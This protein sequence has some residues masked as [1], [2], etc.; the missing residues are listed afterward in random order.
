[1][2]KKSK[3]ERGNGPLLAPMVWLAL[4]AIGR[5][6]TAR[7]EGILTPSIPGLCSGA[8]EPQTASH[9][10]S[11][12]VPLSHCPVSNR[13]VIIGNGGCGPHVYV[14]SFT[15]SNGF[16]RI[17][18]N[19]GGQLAFLYHPGVQLNVS[20]IVINNGGKFEAG[21]SLCPIGSANPSDVSVIRF[22]PANPPLARGIEGIT[23]NQGG[24]LQLYGKTGVAPA[25]PLSVAD[26]QA[27]SWTYLSAPAGPPDLYSAGMGVGNPVGSNGAT[28]LQLADPVD[29]QPGQW[30]V[31]AGTDFSPDSAEFVQISAVSN[32]T[33]QS[34]S[35]IIL[36]STTPLV[37]YHFG[38]PAPDLGANAFNDGPSQNYGVDERAEV[39]LISR[40]LKLTSSVASEP[41]WAPNKQYTARAS[42]IQV[43]TTTFKPLV[44]FAATIAGTSGANPPAWP[45]KVGATVCDGGTGKTCKGGV[46]WKNM[47]AQTEM[48][49]EIR[50][51]AGYKKVEIQGV[52]LEKFG[53]DQL[54]SYPI[55]FHMVGDAPVK[56]TLINSNSIHHGYNHCIAL[57]DTN[58]V[59][60]SNNVCARI[61]DHLYY[62]ETGAETGN[63]FA[64][65]LGI[66]AMSNNFSIT[67]NPPALA[68][69]WPGD[70]LA[71]VNGYNGFN[72]PFTDG[73][74]TAPVIGANGNTSSGFWVTNPG[75]NK[76]VGNSI[77]GCQATG[78]GFWILPASSAIAQ[79]PLPAGHFA[80]NRA[81]GC[82]TGFDTAADD[83]VSGAFLYI[84]Q[85]KCLAGKVKGAGQCDAIA[86]FDNLTATRNRNRGIWV[87]A[88]WYHI[89]GARLAT[90]RDGVSLVSSGGSEG[91]P[92]G[93]W[94]LL[95]DSIAV[96]ISTNNPNRFGP[97]PYVGQNGFGGN[98]GCYEPIQDNG[99]PGPQWN[100]FG[101]M[102][103]DG[104][105]RIENVK[106]VNFKVDPISMLTASDVSF[107]NYFSA[108]NT[109]PCGAPG[110]FKY[111]GDASMGWF[112]SN[113]NSYPP[114]QYTE[115]VSYENVDLRHEIYTGSVENTCSSSSGGANFRDGD[116][117]TVIRDH[118][119]SLTGLEV[120]PQGG[121][122]PVPG[123]LP[124]SL[125]NLPFL[126]G[127]GTV[128]E[129]LS[130]GAQDDALE[131]RPTSLISP[132]NY[133]TLEFAAIT[134]PCNGVQGGAP[135]VNDNVMVF[136]KDEIDYPDLDGPGLIQ[137]T[138]RTITANDTNYS[139]NCGAGA[140]PSSPGVPGHACVALSGRN[141][142]GTYE[143]KVVNGL[144]YTVQAQHGMPNF[145]TLMYGDADVPGGISSANPFRTRIGICYKNEG[146]SAPPV[147][148]F[149]VYKGS[150]SFA[151]PDL[152]IAPLAGYYTPLS[153]NGLDDIMCGSTP[154]CFETKCPSAPYYSTAGDDAVKTKL[155]LATSIAQLD[156]SSMCPNG[157]CYYYDQHSGLLFINMAQE[158]PNA[159]GPYS[160]PLGSCGGS[161]SKANDSACAPENFYSCPGPGCELYT[162][163]VKGKDYSPGTPSDCTPYSGGDTTDYTQ[164]YPSNLNQLA[165]ASND[166]VVQ[167]ALV[168]ADTHYP[169]QEASNPPVDICPINAPNTPDWPPASPSAIPTDYTIS[170]PSG[171]SIALA[172]S[173]GD[174]API[175]Q[176]VGNEL[177]ALSPGLYTLTASL[178]GC[179]TNSKDSSCTCEQDFTVTSSGWSSA[180]N[181]NC[182]QLGTGGSMTTIGVADGPYA[183]AGPGP[184]P[185]PTP[186]P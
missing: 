127:P 148:A 3:I 154:F 125:N 53:K 139:I 92:P 147:D 63:T 61:V 126:A 80:S 169:H 48:G 164:D 37:N 163:K 144:G 55:H 99:Y 41:Q 23:V 132:Y 69:F 175:L 140:E 133:A 18:V 59:T 22:L 72:I 171:V 116:K 83:G 113:V 19:S 29:W 66:G 136:T 47:G 24:T 75:G 151:G 143:P 105:A 109:M 137:F 141:G 124:I 158:Q 85:S 82:Y 13:S 49:G 130:T 6:G 78:R 84:P 64:Y 56:T 73:A 10:G 165:Y 119:A 81:H 21:D 185:A 184:N 135:C 2:K 90:N 39:G 128:D 168:G 88:S 58:D 114:T 155:T 52:E 9:P 12:P 120:V 178:G 79:I 68:A 28:T 42:S 36:D 173:G 86:E 145:V 57:H 110:A 117:F 166:I 102:F 40:N 11:T 31:V 8:F 186:T 65:N 70:Y 5:V 16:R 91:S 123:V 118:D 50:I 179:T 71:A 1:M 134:P 94:S 100:M 4:L 108:N 111:E 152:S 182:C 122:T 76:F 162:I 34:C 93:E 33:N 26:P 103:Y 161:G 174:I 96:G 38:G 101:V 159:G 150:K 156:D 32:C 181:P 98:A 87:R 60:I 35:T 25:T 43:Q 15:D 176:Q 153:C 160:S 138:D 170:F 180:S 177:Y 89:E 115:N 77:A 74:G 146:A 45:A 51:L 62:L 183:C 14:D 97:C 17:T 131:T 157:T 129:C 149:S 121:G 54:G 112:Q 167:P 7:A 30:I 142:Y 67:N 44:V 46:L 20:S 104:P 106:F 172:N 27:P 95:K 107:I